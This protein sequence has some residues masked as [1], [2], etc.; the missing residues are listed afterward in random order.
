MT[1]ANGRS[2]NDETQYDQTALQPARPTLPPVSFGRRI[3]RRSAH[4]PRAPTTNPD[5]NKTTRRARSPAT[6]HPYN[7]ST[8]LHAPVHRSDPSARGD[9]RARPADD[10]AALGTLQHPR[11]PAVDEAWPEAWAS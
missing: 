4:P 7:P 3:L 10:S 8:L 2:D 6:R 1:H 11:L 9:L 5:N